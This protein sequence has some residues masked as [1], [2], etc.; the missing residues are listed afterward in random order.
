[1]F[2]QMGNLPQSRPLLKGCVLV[3][4]Q[5]LTQQFAIDAT[6]HLPV[7][8]HDEQ[9]T[10]EGNRGRTDQHAKSCGVGEVHLTLDNMKQAQVTKNVHVSKPAF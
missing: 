8:G 4:G 5:P 1:M 7:A 10:S 3:P 9:G 2:W 6:F